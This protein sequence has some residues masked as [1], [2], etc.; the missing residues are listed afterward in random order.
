[1]AKQ[2]SSLIGVAAAADLLGVSP[3]QVRNLIK[4]GLLPAEKLG[5][6]YVIRSADV[7]KVPKDRKPGPKPAE[8]KGK[9]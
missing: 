7:A 3:R 5:R 2:D 6:D 4:D 1:M 9:G 8:G